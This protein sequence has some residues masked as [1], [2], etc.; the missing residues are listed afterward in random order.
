MWINSCENGIRLSA[1]IHARSSKNEVIVI[2]NNALKIR[3][4]SPPVDG[5]ANKACIRFFLNC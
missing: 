3:L 2:Y 4:T 5:S 1:I